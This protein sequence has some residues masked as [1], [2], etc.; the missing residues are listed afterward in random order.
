MFWRWLK[1]P[2]LFIFWTI[3][4]SSTFAGFEEE[5]SA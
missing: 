3:V 4:A 2:F 5:L 1:R